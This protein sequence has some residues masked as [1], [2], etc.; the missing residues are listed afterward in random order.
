[1]S[2][3]YYV[4][5]FSVNPTS[6][7]ERTFLINVLVLLFSS[8]G[9]SQSAGDYR[10]TGDGNWSDRTKW[11]RFSGSTWQTP[12]AAQGYPGQS[13]TAGNVQIRHDVILNVS[14]PH[15]VGSITIDGQQSL[16]TSGNPNLK[17]TGNITLQSSYFFVPLPSTLSFGNGDL[18]V[19][20]SISLASDCD[21]TFGTGA[22]TLNGTVALDAYLFNTFPSTFRNNGTATLTNTGSGVISG[23][24]Q[25]VQGTN[26]I[27][28]YAGSTIEADFDASAAGNRVNYNRN[29]T[30]TIYG[31]TYHHLTL[32]NDGAK[33]AAGNF[34]VRG[35]FEISDAA[36][37]THGS[38]TVT[39][40]G[41]TTQTL[42]IPTGISFFGL[43][44][45][46]SGSSSPH[47]SVN[48]GNM[49]VSSVL[50]MTKGN[51][52][53]NG[54]SIS[55]TNSSSGALVYSAG[56]F[57]GGSFSRTRPGSQINVGTPHS[58]FPLGTSTDWRPFY[59]GQNDTGAA[60]GTM[61]V[62][63]TNST[64]TSDVTINDAG[65]SIVRRHNSF[66]TPR[67]TATGGTYT[68][69]AGG[70][71]FGIISSRTHLRM[72]TSTS[73]VGNHVAASTPDYLVNR[74][75]VSR[76]NLNA[77]NFHLASTNGTTS[78]LP[79]EL[80]SFTA[81][82]DNNEVD[83]RWSTASELNNAFFTI[84]RTLNPETFES[85]IEVDGKG[86]TKELSHYQIID[87][88]PMYGRSYYR[89][90]QTDFDGNFTYS[91]V[92]VIDYSGPLYAT[93]TASPNPVNE[94]FLTILLEGLK[95]ARYVPIQ[96]MDIHG[97]IVYEMIFEVKTPGRLEVKV[98]S[99][100][101]TTAGIYVIKAGNTQQ[102]TKK[103]VI[104]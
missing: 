75:N 25:W 67:T 95:E 69:R 97:Q 71:N 33:T 2:L 28:N 65:T 4:R 49:S 84:E 60:A 19:T 40:D 35:D 99:E 63:H 98:P 50:N 15:A 12:S 74:N 87:P 7:L 16:T 101:F 70:S 55:L 93:L 94:A 52:N 20:G 8:Y 45:N 21:F 36:S 14:P 91:P 11:Q 54:N 27:L 89:L 72:S 10:S 102:L 29:N 13:S 61:T 53:L 103:I 76:A 18:T 39:L 79:I 22:L 66:W 56:W 48:G 68:L 17:V 100:T 44:I 38:R 43:T 34:S 104:E 58:L 83:I 6:Y 5:K 85:L 1:M 90:K 32:S 9:F 81:R 62:T 3:L 77:N 96:I 86:T 46:N 59:V 51:V 24:G 57:Y 30:Q 92:Q 47:I 41:S 42:N 73:V 78:P 82:L 26:S 37:F 31:T 88:A 80:L 23:E 64:S